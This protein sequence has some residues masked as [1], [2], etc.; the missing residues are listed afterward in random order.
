MVP[1]WL[2][3]AQFR[4]YVVGIAEAPMRAGGA[5]ALIVSPYAAISGLPRRKKPQLEITTAS[6]NL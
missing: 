5:G 6:A 4:A 3:L 1:H 2:A